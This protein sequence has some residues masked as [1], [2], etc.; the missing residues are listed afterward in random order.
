[1]N[2]LARRLK[3]NCTYIHTRMYVRS[4]FDALKSNEFNELLYRRQR[5]RRMQIKLSIKN[6]L[7][8]VTDFL[9]KRAY[10]IYLFIL[11]FIYLFIFK[12]VRIRLALVCGFFRQTTFGTHTNKERQKSQLKGICT[13]MYVRMCCGAPG[14]ASVLLIA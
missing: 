3:I 10:K 9:V 13:C 11:F 4:S 14:N 5:R 8:S 6:N 12:F 7:N 1:M 2:Y